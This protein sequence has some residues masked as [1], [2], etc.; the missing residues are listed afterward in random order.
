MTIGPIG[1]CKDCCHWDKM[2]IHKDGAARCLVVEDHQS[3][4]ENRDYKIAG[5]GF[6]ID[7]GVSDDSGLWIYMVTGPQFGCV[8]FSLRG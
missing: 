8:K 7:Y 6:A 2:W 3:Y 1:H 4:D 5:D